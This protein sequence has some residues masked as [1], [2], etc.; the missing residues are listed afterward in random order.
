[1]EIQGFGK[2]VCGD[3]AIPP[4]C[5]SCMYS[6][7]LKTGGERLPG[8]ALQSHYHLWV[9]GCFGL[10]RVRPVAHGYQHVPVPSLVTI[11]REPPEHVCLSLGELA[12]CS[13]RP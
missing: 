9:L 5:C 6:A 4:R 10:A 11:L 1:M 2:R 12:I 7:S 8:Y 13:D 3:D